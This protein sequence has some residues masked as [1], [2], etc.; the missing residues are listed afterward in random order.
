M[1]YV[2]ALAVRVQPANSCKQ[3]GD[4]SAQLWLQAN[5]SLA[6]EEELAFEH[7]APNWEG[8]Q[9][10]LQRGCVSCLGGR[11]HF[12]M[13]T[14]R[15]GSSSLQL[16]TACLQGEKKMVQCDLLLPLRLGAGAW[17][18]LP[19]LLFLATHPF[20]SSWWVGNRSES[21]RVQAAHLQAAPALPQ[22]SRRCSSPHCA[23][24]QP[25]EPASGALH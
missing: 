15:R 9:G 13:P 3:A 12:S 2:K 16:L 22:R 25:R 11:L 18:V 8:L 6:G 1:H 24:T 23:C 7:K 20:S 21:C 17:H 14:R 4:S 10:F 19:S 5:M